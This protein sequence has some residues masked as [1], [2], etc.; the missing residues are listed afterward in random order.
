MIFTNYFFGSLKSFVISPTPEP[1]M[2]KMREL[3][4]NNYFFVSSDLPTLAFARQIIESNVQPRDVVR[5]EIV[6]RLL[7]SLIASTVDEFLKFLTG[8]DKLATVSSWSMAVFTATRA[9]DYI[10]NRNVKDGRCY[11]GN[12]IVCEENFYC[13]MTSP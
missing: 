4:E 5:T 7:S 10:G 11:I 6:K 3:I 8:A 2:T 1:R 9:T 13:L 12:E